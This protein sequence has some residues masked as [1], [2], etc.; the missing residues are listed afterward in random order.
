VRILVD[1]S[2][3][4]LLNIGDVA[5]LQSC[6]TRLR[7][8]WPDA[9]IMVVCHS[10]ARL[11]SYCP[12]TVAIGQTFAD[13][14][15]FRAVPRR[16]RLAAEQAWKMAAPYFSGRLGSL[17]RGRPPRTAIQ[18]VRAADI[19]VASG[20]GYV[21]DTWWW[22]AAGV[23]SLLAL[24]QREGKPT[25]MFGQGIGPITQRGLRTQAGAV[26]RRLTV[27]GLREAR[28][29][30]DLAL[31]LGTRPGAITVTGDDALELIPPTVP[32][33]HA[34]GVNMRVSDYAGVDPAAAQTVGEVVTQAADAYGAPLV[35]L[36]VSRYPVDGDLSAIRALLRREHSR[37]GTVLDDLASPEALA[38]A[39]SGCRAV[40][41]G[42]YHAAVFS[43]A[44]GVPAVCLTKS[45]YYDA[46]FAGL[47]ELFPGACFVG[48]LSQPDFA[49]WLRAAID[50][51]W[52]LPAP[53][54]AAARE[55]AGRQRQAG[56]EAYAQFQVAAGLVATDREG[57][58]R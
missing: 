12:G 53:A 13:R 4:D 57:L 55:A 52:N 54:R 29:G 11:A 56:R 43:L 20:G 24:A 37:P 32:G 46:K 19:V 49:D 18:A 22:H 31:S 48:S 23:L 39:A 50:Q 10:P 14:P 33:G 3:Y 17:G 38:T 26:L 58:L 36:P 1:Q 7:Q 25:A 5:M 21:T 44:Q 47:S 15:G 41:T 8:L 16:P 42:S 30:H 28:V 51:A 45:S 9:E 34:L 6:V 40:V 2:G 27:L 35:A